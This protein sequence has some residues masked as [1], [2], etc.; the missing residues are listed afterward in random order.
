MHTKQWKG[1]S[2]HKHNDG[3]KY[4]HQKISSNENSH[5]TQPWML[6]FEFSQL[7]LMI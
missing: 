5:Y 1:N 6:P 4:A 3:A 7:D 2:E